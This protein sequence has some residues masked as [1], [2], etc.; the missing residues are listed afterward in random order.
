MGTRADFYVGRGKDAEWIGSIA[1]DGYPSGITAVV[2]DAVDEHSYRTAV[3][4]FLQ[5]RRDATYPNEGWPW[6]WEDSQTTDYAYA[7]EDGG[8]HY[9]HFG[10]AWHTHADGPTPSE[11]IDEG[12]AIFPN[13]ADR[14][15]VQLSGPKSGLIVV[16]A[17][18]DG[19]MGYE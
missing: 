2:L 10:Y 17:Y 14:T 7:F 16:T 4:D 3:S 11:W 8:V 12:S 9:S 15:K 1:W 13:M 19:T 5:G 18:S 6:P